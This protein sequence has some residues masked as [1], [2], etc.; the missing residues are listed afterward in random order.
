MKGRRSS[1]ASSDLPRDDVLVVG[2]GPAGSTV[3]N[4]LAR[5]GWSVRVVDR[6]RFPRAKPCGE[7]VNPGAVAVLERLGLLR[8]VLR[9]SPARLQGWRIRSEG[10]PEAVGTF[11]D[12]TVDGIGVSRERFDHALLRAARHR[13]AAVTEGVTVERVRN[14]ATSGRPSV[15]LRTA[16]GHRTW[17]TARVVIGA[18]GLRSV[19]AR[20]I[21]AYRRRPRL[22]K[23]SLTV[24]LRGRG[25]DRDRGRL[26]LSS[27]RVL[28]LA[29]VHAE[30]PLWN[31]TVV[32][33]ADRY[34]RTVAGDPAGFVRDVLAD[35]PP[36]WDRPPRILDG[37][38]SSGPFD[39]PVRRRTAPGI[40]LVGDAA[41]YYDPLTGQG[42][43]R[44][45][46]SAELA[47]GIIDRALREDRVSGR[48]LRSY[49]RAVRS[50]FRASR[51]VQRAIEAVVSRDAVRH[52]VFDRLAR[53][54]SAFDSLIRVTGD[55]A[56]VRS[57][58]HPR[59]WADVLR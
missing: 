12:R 27:D 26:L 55:A 3:A 9:L 34:G 58:L 4:L 11:D 38:W 50:E 41:G 56:P 29:P 45:L 14:G 21:R 46:R 35:A 33:D 57:L 18:D 17:R 52:R 49:D 13:G 19:T 40:V 25:P 31:A 22:R 8:R 2:G 1:G 43:F 30:R 47:A 10:G 59:P 28:G 20:E 42:I 44:A 53:A 36:D 37:P 32:V 23:L 6:A 7:C 48:C 15:R 39:W 24:R 16:D 54:P 5:R 51:W